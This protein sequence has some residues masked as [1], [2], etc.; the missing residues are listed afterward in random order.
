MLKNIFIALLLSGCTVD[1]VEFAHQST[2]ETRSRGVAIHHS[3]NFAQIGMIGNVCEIQ[4]STGFIGSDLDMVVG[5]EDKVEDTFDSLTLVTGTSGNQLYILDRSNYSSYFVDA[6]NV[7]HARFF[8]DGIVTLGDCNVTW[9]STETERSSV[10]VPCGETLT[11]DTTTGTAYITASSGLVIATPDGVETAEVLG[12]LLAFDSLLG[13][14]YVGEDGGST[15]SGLQNGIQIWS[16]QLDQPISSLDDM[17]ERG[18][19]AV[20]I[21]DSDSGGVVTLD[22]LSGEVIS[23]F[24]TP[25]T[26]DNIT[27]SGDGS[28]IGI[29]LPDEVHFYSIE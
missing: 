4:T 11:V 13:I 23:V 27:V 21:G 12:S 25:S 2:L 1:K 29:T 28:V 14:L 3:G 18:M 7:D 20:M 22:G 26:A 10:E 19:V 9:I 17:G 6:E 8:N 16:T 5:E 24:E 15:V